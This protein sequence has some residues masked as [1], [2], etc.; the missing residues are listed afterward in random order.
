MCAFYIHE[1]ALRLP[2]GGADV[3]SEQLHRLLRLGVRPN[4]S[5]RVLPAAIGPLAATAGPF[6]MMEF[7][8]IKPVVYLES[9]TSSLFLELPIEIDAYRSI[10]DSLDATALSEGQ[11]REFI[12]DLAVELY[13]DREDEDGLAQEQ[14][15]Q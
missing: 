10:L 1:F 12:G 7:A 15:Q 5:I 9:E 13:G 4:V 2:V 6:I 8:E 14:L 3:M 11:S